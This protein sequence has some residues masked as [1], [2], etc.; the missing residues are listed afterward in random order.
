MVISNHARSTFLT[1]QSFIHKHIGWTCFAQ[2]DLPRTTHK[3]PLSSR[4]VHDWLELWH[5][6]F[7]SRDVLSMQIRIFLHPFYEI[8]SPTRA[9][10]TSFDRLGDVALSRKCHSGKSWHYEPQAVRSN[11]STTD[12]HEPYRAFGLSHACSFFQVMSRLVALPANVMSMRFTSFPNP[13]EPPRGVHAGSRFIIEREKN[14]GILSQ[15]MFY[16]V[17]RSTLCKQYVHEVEKHIRRCFDLQNHIIVCSIC[18]AAQTSII[19]VGRRSV[20]RQRA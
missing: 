12:T 8:T 14:Y 4:S 20:Q 19:I 17:T 7:S 1:L 6:N 16:L 15:R 3:T 10:Q 11:P 18:V 2:D 9:L 5:F 13:K